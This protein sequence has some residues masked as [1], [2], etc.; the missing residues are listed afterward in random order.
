MLNVNDVQKTNLLFQVVT[1]KEE[2]KSR[3]EMN[4]KVAMV[5]NLVNLF[6]QGNALRAQKTNADKKSQNPPK[7]KTMKINYNL[8]T[9]N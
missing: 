5:D 9:E 1:A 2:S 7:L 8:K 3:G 4:A 6:I